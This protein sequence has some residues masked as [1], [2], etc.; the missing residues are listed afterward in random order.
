M[1]V[2]LILYVTILQSNLD[3]QYEYRRRGLNHQLDQLGLHEGIN[4][5]LSGKRVDLV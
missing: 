2:Q 3:R 5:G 4:Y 1:N